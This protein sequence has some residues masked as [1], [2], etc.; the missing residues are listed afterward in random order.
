MAINKKDEIVNAIIDGISNKTRDGILKWD[1]YSEDIFSIFDDYEE[2]AEEVEFDFKKKHLKHN[3]KNKGIE[4]IKVEK[5]IYAKQKLNDDNL[6]ISII[7]CK[8]EKGEENVDNGDIYL[9]IC[10][11]DNSECYETI[12][13]S[14]SFPNIIDL[15]ELSIFVSSKEIQE[16]MKNFI[17]R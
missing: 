12:A 5:S 15:Y 16:V 3:Y 2:D 11:F 6:R 8:R 13:E 10:D 1:Y 17:N 7:K 9:L 14:D 4:K